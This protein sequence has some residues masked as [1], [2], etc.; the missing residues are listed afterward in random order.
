[1]HDVL[2]V[3]GVPLLLC[4]DVRARER[5]EKLDVTEREHTNL[6]VPTHEIKKKISLKRKQTTCTKIEISIHSQ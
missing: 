5:R 4:E 3:G 1:M 2:D 6:V